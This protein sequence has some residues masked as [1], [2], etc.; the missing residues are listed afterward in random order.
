MLKHLVILAV[1]AVA[2][3]GLNSPV[4][5]TEFTAGDDVISAVSGGLNE[6]SHVFC[7]F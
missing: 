7:S 3:T 1:L 4:V 5:P 6:I 2:V